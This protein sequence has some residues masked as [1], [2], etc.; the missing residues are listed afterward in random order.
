MTPDKLASLIKTSMGQEK[1][2][3]VI[4]SVQLLNVYSKEILPDTFIAIKD[5]TIV[6]VGKEDKNLIGNDTLIID[7]ENCYA[8][9]GF[10]EAHTHIAQLFKISYFSKY[11]AQNGVTTVI[12]ECGELGN[13]FGKSGIDVYLQKISSQPIN[14][15]LTLPPLT[16]P[17]PQF[18]TSKG[19]TLN[20]YKE[21]LDN[22]LVIGLGESYWPRV[23]SCD[24][25]VMELYSYALN[26]NKILQAHS[27]GAKG[28]KLNA[29]ITSGVSGCHEPVT[30]QEIIDRMRLGLELILR[31]GSVRRDFSSIFSKGFKLADYR[32]VAIAT[33][34]VTPVDLINDGLLNNI[35]KKAVKFGIDPIEV[36]RMLT[37]NPATFFNIHH[38]FGGIAPNKSAD[39]SIV[40]N[41]Q[42]FNIKKVF[43]KGKLIFD[44]SKNI[45]FTSH[46]LKY[47]KEFYNNIG[48]E[49]QSIKD[50]K[51]NIQNRNS[52]KVRAVRLFKELVTQ[53]EVI[54]LPV[55]KGDIDISSH[56]D[57][58]KYAVYNRYGEYRKNLGF[59]I[60][61]GI[62][63]GAFASTFNWE[64]YQ[65]IVFGKKE[66][67]MVIAINRLI[68][69]NGGIVLVNNGEVLS[70]IPLSIG[71]IIS[72]LSIEELAE[73][74]AILVKKLKDLGCTIDNSFMILQTLSFTGLPFIRL[75]DKGL[76]DIKNQKFVP[77]IVD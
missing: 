5:D 7:G 27:A 59:L 6:Y 46:D 74:E 58:L 62:S 14:I 19:L 76:V 69:I 28:N 71:G 31:E 29:Y 38:R 25:P 53:E 61:T 15:F 45:D 66:S 63:S 75:T 77:I 32:M 24:K 20:D 4:S 43:S 42:D 9:P 37:I 56:N 13:V 48:I 60:G 1:A 35:A 26:K 23:I 3:K 36:V 44:S 22:P 40:E 51:F 2:D 67:D 47:P 65:P 70:E 34:G 10:I 73:R 39:I 33:D 41:L 30:S 11:A 16:P 18:E 68:D 54:E 57:L 52:V 12:T 50:F 55:N 21:L 17:F 64:N 72:D 49:K 8:I